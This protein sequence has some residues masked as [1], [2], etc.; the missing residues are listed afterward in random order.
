VHYASGNAHS[1]A[2]GRLSYL[3][4]LKGP[5]LSV[6]TAC[7]SSLVA[8]HLA[9]QALRAGECTLAIA[10]G[11]NVILA[12]ETT[13]ALS[14]AHMMSPDGRS[15]AF[16]DR[17]DGFARAEGC[18]VV[19]LKPLAQA[20]ADGDPVLAVIRGTALNQDGASSSLTAPHGPSQ[21]DLMRRALADAG[22]DAGQVD[23]V[24]TH[25]TGTAL[26]D[27]IELRALG[28][29]YGQAHAPGRPLLIG[30]LK[31][32]LGHMEAAAGIGGLIK[33][34]LS[35]QHGLAPAHLLLQ[36]PTRHVSWIDLNLSVPTRST[37]WP[38]TK[39]PDGTS[40]PR[41]GAVSAFG[42][43]GT[44]AHLVVEQAPA[45]A[46]AE[47]P[48][49][50]T[51]DDTPG[52]AQILPVS[53]ASPEALEA[54]AQRYLAWL[55]SPTAQEFSWAEIAATAS[56][57]RDSLRYRCAVVARSREEAANQ[58]RQLPPR[59]AVP[60]STPPHLCF[61]FTG[62]GSE[63]PGVGLELLQK[64]AVF[65][66]SIERLEA[67]LDGSLGS[68]LA[69]IWASK[70][71]E[72]QQARLV[73]PALFAF[74]W[75]LS[76]LWRSWGVEPAIVL[77]HSLGEYI[78]ATVAGVLSP[79][80][81]IRLVAARGRLTGQL[82]EPGAMVAVV[83]PEDE[84]RRLIDASSVQSTLSI[85]AVNG[86]ESVV[87]SGPVAAVQDFESVLRSAGLRHKRLNTSHG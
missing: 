50:P 55:P 36:T 33:L 46:L 49:F 35:L 39:R 87:V 75:A 51:D 14:H 53:A 66:A 48:A 47:S 13:V 26:G 63:H 64:S 61:L 41:L 11:V 30:S 16:D 25:G 2:S 57:C 81:A 28:A 37:P 78:A 77:G 56:E 1:I 54:L 71:G 6:D 4:G 68:S 44:N 79:E 40:A 21:E 83:A 15:K 23:Y 70:N 24:E 32:N 9:C 69:R 10:A 3:L 73:Q 76:E 7:S 82:A 45:A 58:L 52:H 38:E 84:I 80:D 59:D 34:V 85:A 72:L 19:I 74:G 86:P 60:V 27:P 5:S 22:C 29:V 12:P 65:R 8:V 43:S 31:T 42:F 18:G 67:A 20:L 17:A 62:Q